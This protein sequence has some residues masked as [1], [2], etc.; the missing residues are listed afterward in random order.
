MAAL[1][2][3]ELLQKK[4]LLRPDEVASILRVSVRTVYNMV[5]DGRLTAAELGRIVRV[6]SRSVA[7]L[8]EEM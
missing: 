3:E 6:H 8:I 2:P 1:T 4:Q 5:A 7:D